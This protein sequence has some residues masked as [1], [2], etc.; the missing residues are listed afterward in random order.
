MRWCGRRRRA[1]LLHDTP[2]D[3]GASWSSARQAQ[4]AANSALCVPP[5]PHAPAAWLRRR[6]TSPSFRDTRRTSSAT[7]ALVGVEAPASVDGN[8]DSGDAG[9]AAGVLTRGEAAT[10]EEAFFGEPLELVLAL[11]IASRESGLETRGDGDALFVPFTVSV[12]VAMA[13]SRRRQASSTR[14]KNY[15]GTKKE[16]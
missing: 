3:A 6:R 12:V 4:S 8:T 1:A 10:G 9:A 2:R 7:A 15:V 16:N 11:S 5:R 13:S 14:A